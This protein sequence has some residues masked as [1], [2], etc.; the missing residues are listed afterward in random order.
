V[1][2]WTRVDVICCWRWRLQWMVPF[3]PKLWWQ[4][5]SWWTAVVYW[6]AAVRIQPTSPTASWEITSMG[7]LIRCLQCTALAF[8]CRHSA[9]SNTDLVSFLILSLL[10]LTSHIV[11]RYFAVFFSVW[12]D[13]LAAVAPIGAKFC[14]M[15]HIGPGTMFSTLGGG[16]PK[17]SPKS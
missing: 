1:V 8:C 17:G 11:A 13:I 16:T 7:P 3:L 10:L 5:T 2:L 4:I 15:V 12:L 14:M 9:V 6:W